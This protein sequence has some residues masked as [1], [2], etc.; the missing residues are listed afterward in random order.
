MNNNT[1]LSILAVGVLGVIIYASGAG[2]EMFARNNPT[3]ETAQLRTSQNTSISENSSDLFLRLVHN[4]NQ[5]LQELEIDVDVLKESIGEGRENLLSSGGAP[6]ATCQGSNCPPVHCVAPSVCPTNPLTT[7]VIGSA[8][9]YKKSQSETMALADCNAK[10]ERVLEGLNTCLSARQ[11][12]C[13]LAGNLCFYEEEL[14]FPESSCEVGPDG[15]SSVGGGLF[16]RKKWICI[17]SAM[18]PVIRTTC[19]G[20]SAV[21]SQ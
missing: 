4:L 11:I 8:S 12:E 5:Q 15:C 10:F 13:R 21:I 1:L 18:P 2:D 3:Q 17:A 16:S 19:I 9:H 14:I 7:V 20:E 6:E